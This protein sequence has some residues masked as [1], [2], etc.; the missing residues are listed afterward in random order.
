MVSVIFALVFLAT[1]A[2]G[3]PEQRSPAPPR[4]SALDG[5]LKP[6][7]FLVG[8]CWTGAFAS[9][10]KDMHCFESLYG[11]HFVRDR[12][13]VSGAAKP[14]EGETLYRWDAGTG[15]IRYAY[16][17][18]DGGVSE[19]TAQADGTALMFPETHRDPAG[20]IQEYRNAWRQTGPDEYVALTEKKTPSG[21]EEAFKIV[22]RRDARL[23]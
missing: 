14:Y 21:W 13:R 7:K 15:T 10:A 12:H 6:F 19:G 16:Y 9:G 2:V 18:S 11:G 8:S 3:S 5:P 1:A 23:P 4:G 22:F 17:N 20:N